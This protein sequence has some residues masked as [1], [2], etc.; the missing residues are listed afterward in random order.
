MKNL[1]ANEISETEEESDE[2]RDRSTDRHRSVAN[3]HGNEEVEI[4]GE[5]EGEVREESS[6]SS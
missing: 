1:P 6:G 4:R 5:A 3:G 2:S